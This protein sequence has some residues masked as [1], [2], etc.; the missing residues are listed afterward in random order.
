MKYNPLASTMLITSLLF[1]GATATADDGEKVLKSMS[2]TGGD[3]V[4]DPVPEA[5]HA[6]IDTM[7]FYV[8]AQASS[9]EVTTIDYINADGAL[10]ESR[11][12]AKPLIGVYIYGPSVGVEGTGFV[13]HGKRDA[14]AA[15]SLDDGTTWK[16]TNLSESAD[17]SSRRLVR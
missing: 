13:G 5:E 1:A 9:G 2:K 7:K 16:A 10:V 11:T 6:F 15:V 8:R 4:L 14:F 3:S 17:A 12:H